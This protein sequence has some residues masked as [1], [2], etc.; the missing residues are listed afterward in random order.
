MVV[1]QNVVDFAVHH[2]TLKEA[3]VATPDGGADYGFFQDATDGAFKRALLEDMPGGSG[4]LADGDYGDVTVSSSGTVINIDANAVGTTEIADA[5]VTLAKMANIAT[6]TLIGRDTAATGVPEAITLTN[7]LGFTGSGSIGII[8]NAIVTAM[9]QDGVVTAAKLDA[10]SVITALGAVF[11]GLDATLTALAGLATGADKLAYST[12]T[13][14]FA[15]TDFTSTARSLLDD[16][17]VDAMRATLGVWNVVGKSTTETRNLDTTLTDDDELLFSVDASSL[18]LF[19]GTIHFATHTTPDFK[20]GLAGPAATTIRVHRRSLA[21]GASSYGAIAVD[22]V[23]SGPLSLLVGAI[24]DGMIFF[25]VSL[26]VGGSGGTVSF[27]WA[28]NTSDSADT[29]VRAGSYIEWIKVT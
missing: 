12:G 22:D 8:A 13:N 27:Q 29:L 14:T 4:G 6:D 23:Y 17:S 7:G 28:Q 9:I 21:P 26:L 10:A 18:Y 2:S 15:Q 20:W 1:Y 3:A 11:Q 19:R 16:A 5:A 25:E 24:D